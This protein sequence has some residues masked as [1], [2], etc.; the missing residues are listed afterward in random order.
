VNRMRSLQLDIIEGPGAG[1]QVPLDAPKVIGRADDADITTGDDRTSRHHARVCPSGS[2]AL[3]EDLDS[4]NGT[5]VN[6]DEVAAP[7]VLTPGDELLVGV[8]VFLVRD[9]AEAR[10]RPSA[11]RAVPPALAATPRP[12]AYVQRDAN[13]GP[14]APPARPA[15]PEL[16]RLVDRRT[17][18]RARLAPLAILVLVAIALMVYFAAT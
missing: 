11:V 12:P 1:R 6:G 13:G 14:A 7:T 8:T 9:R 3:V 16:E 5:F 4:T 10:D 2:G 18:G 15:V 17:K